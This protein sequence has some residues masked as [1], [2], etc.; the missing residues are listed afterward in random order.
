MS[1]LA[2]MIQEQGKEIKSLKSMIHDLTLLVMKDKID[3]T[4]L[5]EKQASEVLGLSGRQFRRNVVLSKSMMER[6]QKVTYPFNLIEYRHTNGRNYQYSRKSI[7][8]FKQLTSN[9]QA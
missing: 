3:P 5:T 6:N 8:K 9:T 1:E 2:V 4:W 7:L